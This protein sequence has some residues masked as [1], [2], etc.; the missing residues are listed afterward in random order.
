MQNRPIWIKR[1]ADFNVACILKRL[2]FFARYTIFFSFC[3]FIFYD[4][5]LLRPDKFLARVNK[6]GEERDLACLTKILVD[7]EREKKV[8]SNVSYFVP[9]YSSS[10]EI[11]HGPN[12]G[13][14]L[15]SVFFNRYKTLICYTL[16]WLQDDFAAT[17]VT[18]NYQIEI[19]F[20][21]SLPWLRT[22]VSCL[23]ILK[24]IK[25]VVATTIWIFE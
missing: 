9:K 6:R 15:I 16:P 17:P 3:Y 12:T 5:F 23:W 24:W 18:I 8:S 20:K 19:K 25:M 2:C 1:P 10:S 22:I 21:I 7:E 14:F 11:S 13:R 4:P